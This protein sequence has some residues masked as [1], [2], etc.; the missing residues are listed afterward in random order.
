VSERAGEVVLAKVDVDANP[1]VSATFQV[2]S[3]PAVYALKDRRVVSSFIGAQPE[4]V[5]RAWLAEVAPA[6][7][8]VDLLVEAGDE[9]SLRKALGLEPANTTV[10]ISLAT[11]LVD[12]GDDPARQEA[13]QL[14]GRLPETPDVRRLQAQARVGDEAANGTTAVTVKLD[15]LLDRVKA[16]PAARQEYLDLLEV[17][18]VDDPRVATYRKALTARLF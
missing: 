12:R 18:G 17:M 8:E 7:T 16:D 15:A 10:I 14:L 3:I 13:L 11:L 4:P 6:P 9:A 1:R 5:V 2:Q